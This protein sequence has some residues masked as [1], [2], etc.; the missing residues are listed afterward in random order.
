MNETKRARPRKPL[1]VEEFADY[2]TIKTMEHLATM[3]T[4][5]R[6]AR[7]EAFYRTA[8]VARARHARAAR[9]RSSRA[10]SRGR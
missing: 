4:E 7:L 6:K 8:A 5:E 1:T 9:T 10:S 3:P 2:M